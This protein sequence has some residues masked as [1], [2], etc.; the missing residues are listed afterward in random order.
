MVLVRDGGNI[1]H[2]GVSPVLGLSHG[3]YN[4]CD[5]RKMRFQFP[6]RGIPLGYVP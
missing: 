3:Q 5:F 1:D 6:V 4:L 2:A